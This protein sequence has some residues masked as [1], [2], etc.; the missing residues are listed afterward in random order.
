MVWRTLRFVI[1]LAAVV[2]A[3]HTLAGR[4]MAEPAAARPAQPCYPR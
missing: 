4:A 2:A 1:V 3:V